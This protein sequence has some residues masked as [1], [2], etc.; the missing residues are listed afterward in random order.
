MRAILDVFCSYH[1]V[2][3][4]VRAKHSSAALPRK[5]FVNKH[6]K[7][8]NNHSFYIVNLTIINR[9]FSPWLKRTIDSARSALLSMN[10]S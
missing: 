6:L 5:Q 8:L 9:L 2:I 4:A 10:E 3:S 1:A 7:H